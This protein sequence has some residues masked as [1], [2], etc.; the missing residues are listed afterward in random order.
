[1]LSLAR[2]TKVQWVA[3]T[4]YSED[5]AAIHHHHASRVTKAYCPLAVIDPR[6]P[7]DTESFLRAALPHYLKQ[8]D[9]WSL[10]KGVL[11]AYLDAKA[12]ADYLQVRGTK[13]AVAMEMLKEAFLAAAG[14]AQFAR[15]ESDFKDLVPELKRSIGQVLQKHKWEK[16][17]RAVVYGNLAALNRVPFRD[18]IS[19]LCL[20]VGLA[21]PE[22]D[23]KL[24]GRC[25]DSL[26][27]TGRFYS[28]VA[29]EAERQRIAPPS[30]PAHEYFWLLHVLDRLFLRIL[31]Y[32]GPYID[33]SEIGNP[34]RKDTF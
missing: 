4:D 12:E 22:A 28:E 32:S 27:H 15:P 7:T 24:F 18:H 5:G 8:K 29:N 6:H 21:L 25:R 2:G 14:R 31:G 11:D 26:V 17:Q 1:L 34:L 9:K 33:W 19:D 13:L 3:R 23:V 10:T 20:Q 30:T 16:P